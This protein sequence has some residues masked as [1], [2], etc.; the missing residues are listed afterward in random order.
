MSK[1]TEKIFMQM[2]EYLSQFNLKNDKEKEERIQEF[3]KKLNDNNLEINIDNPKFKSDDLLE[4]AFE[5]TSKTKA[6]KLAKQAL[7]IYPD[8]IDAENFI[9]EFESNPI[10]KLSKYSE[11]ERKA[12]ELLKKND[13]FE[14]ENIG[15]FWGLIETRPYMRTRHNKVLCL[16]TLGRYTEAI[17]ECEG[18]LTLCENDNMGI[19]YIL[20]GLYV[21]LER[22]EDC[23]KLYK[24]YNS[25][26]TANFLLP[27]CIMYFK[28][29]DYKK[30][31]S[32][33]KKL[34]NS[35][36]FI[37][38]FLMDGLDFNEAYTNSMYVTYGSEEEAYFTIN[39][40]FYLIN[41]VPYFLEYIENEY[42]NYGI[43]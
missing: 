1:E 26:D 6:I 39:G 36:E 43:N 24:K 40:L 30:T 13:M 14:K 27:M 19:R 20:I 3:I 41:S 9:V 21:L 18:L 5:C 34:D 29:G 11:I 35:N 2:E 42:R 7:E 10:K 38:D 37:I 32:F 16:M 25:D 17:R 28:K 33:L 8:N 12:E 4:I 22:F 15:H 31:K 23:E